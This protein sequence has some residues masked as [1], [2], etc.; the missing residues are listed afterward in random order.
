MLTLFILLTVFVYF[1]VYKYIELPKSLLVLFSVLF[2]SGFL[3][4]TVWGNDFYSISI[5]SSN[6]T[7]RTFVF[8]YTEEFFKILVPLF[9]IIIYSIL[10]RKNSFSHFVSLYFLSTLSFLLIEN[11]LYY[12]WFAISEN[13]TAGWVMR[14]L[15]SSAT[16]LSLAVFVYLLGRENGLFKV[17]RLF[18]AILVAGFLHGISNHLLSNWFVLHVFL[19]L[20]PFYFLFAHIGENSEKYIKKEVTKKDT[21]LSVFI[22]ILAF[23]II[24]PANF[25]SNEKSS[26]EIYVKTSQIISDY[27]HVFSIRESLR[28]DI[29]KT[30]I[31]NIEERKEILKKYDIISDNLYYKRLL[32][33]SKN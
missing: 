32:E 31:S 20:I 6:T 4:Y 12:L 15:F 30:D 2:F 7:F 9:S 10:T 24:S 22:T 16:H 3:G 18:Y 23:F 21:L 26:F 19:T 27:T 1:L 29:L 28:A 17:S 5:F 8:A 13:P 11:Y 25:T 14:A 33:L